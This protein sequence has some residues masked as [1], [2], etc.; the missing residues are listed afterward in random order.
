[1]KIIVLNDFGYVEGGASQVALSSAQ[2]LAAR[3]HS[4]L[5]LCAVGPVA[6]EL[7]GIPGLSV[8]CLGIHEI[9]ADPNRLRAAVQGLWNNQASQA[10]R[11]A[12]MEWPQQETVVHLH[13][14]TKALS[15]SVVRAALDLG[16]PIVLTMHDYFSAC[17][18]GS[19]YIHPTK[20]LC[21]LRAMSPECKRTQCDSRSYSHKLW[22][23]GRQW[24][25]EHQGHLPSGIQNF[26]SISDTSE[27]LLRPYLPPTARIYRVSNPIAVPPGKQVVPSEHRTFSFLG[28]LSPEKGPQLLAHCAARL[29]LKIR[30][31]GEGPERASLAALAPKAEFTGWLPPSTALEAV[32]SSRALVLPSLWYETQGL[33]VAEAAAMGLPAIVPSECAARQWVEDGVTGFVFRHGDENDL[34]QKLVYLEQNPDVANRMGEAAFLR[35]WENPSTMDHHCEQLEVVYA[36]ML[37]DRVSSAPC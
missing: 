3:G 29:N 7:Q 34:G 5:L 4:V 37:A 36:K 23:V 15:S 17:P 2:A 27:N 24:M 6:A 14:W 32:R 20:S 8:R 16:L 11:S 12:A 28:R 13:T 21:L 1:M 35:Y 33:V 19:F 9:V 26:I 22:R 10:F 31:I 30:F 18:T 25:Q